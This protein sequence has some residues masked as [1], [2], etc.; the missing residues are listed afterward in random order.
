M[1]DQCALLLGIVGL[2][3]A[4]TSFRCTMILE[5][6]TA[7]DLDFNPHTILKTSNMYY[8]NVQ[9]HQDI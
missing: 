2:L 4:F 7:T 8:V 6:L 5:E 9:Q 3:F 1:R